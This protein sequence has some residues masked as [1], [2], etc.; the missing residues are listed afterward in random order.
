MIL[1]GALVVLGHVGGGVPYGVIAVCCGLLLLGVQWQ[2]PALQPV[3]SA[4]A[5]DSGVNQEQL[6]RELRRYPLNAAVLGVYA[7]LVVMY[8]YQLA[9]AATLSGAFAALTLSRALLCTRH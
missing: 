2:Y 9:V 5:V 7:G 3:A 6:R 1:A 8:V 4:R